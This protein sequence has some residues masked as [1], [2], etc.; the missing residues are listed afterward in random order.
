MYLFPIYITFISFFFSFF[1][2][3][4]INNLYAGILTSLSVF[5]GFI[6]SLFIF[7]EVAICQA[8]VLINCSNW[9]ITGLLEINWTFYYDS[10]TVT[11]L[12]VIL[13]ISACAH[14]YSIEY[15][16]NDPHQIKFMSYLS[17]FTFFML[18]LVTSSNFIILFVGWEGVGICSYLLINFW[19]TRVGA[20]KSAIMAMFV[21]KIGDVSLL[22]SFT[23]IYFIVYTFDF[24]IFFLSLSSIINTANIFWMFSR[25]VNTTLVA[26]LDNNTVYVS[27]DILFLLGLIGIF[28]VIGAVGKSAQ[29]G[30]HTWLPEAMEGPTPVS[31]LIH[32]ATMVTAGIFL[33][34]RTNILFQMIG[35]LFIVIIA[36]G[37]ITAFMGSTIGIFQA[38][39]KKI[40]AYS[41]CSQLGYMFLAC[42]L[43]GY[44]F[45]IYHLTNH[46]FF[47]AL[48]F[49][50][51]GYIIHAINN[52]QDIRKMGGL[53]SILPFAYI[54]LTIGSLSLLGFPF[55]SGFYSKE[56]IIELFYSFSNYKILNVYSINSII[57]FQMLANI[58][59]TFTVLYSVKVLVYVFFYSYQNNKKTLFNLHYSSFVTIIP[60]FFLSILSIGSGYLLEDMMVGFSTDLWNSSIYKISTGF[61]MNHINYFE[62]NYLS[63]KLPVYSIFY[64]MILFIILF[65]IMGNLLF[66]VKIMNKWTDSFYTFFNKKYILLNKNIYYP[67]INLFF[68]FSYDSM[69][70]LFDKGI[71][72]VLG[73][74]GIV[75]ILN[76]AIV[77]NTKMQTGMV[78]HYFGLMVL[79]ILLFILL[80]ILYIN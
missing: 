53:L 72:E 61:Y 29:V 37:S 5:S 38:D 73:P 8:P 42:G 50:V 57:F 25:L 66:Y 67:I 4:F 65:Y 17:L 69:Y 11:M 74:F 62:F 60:L 46:A 32:A 77:T 79:S 26:A 75:S 64:F 43:S 6:M 70:K 30:L 13:S 31:S 23:L 55:F 45:S 47:K 51:A 71:I 59:V 35:N 19:H 16:L 44:E 9:I 10:L 24:S 56:K 34:I 7:Y 54:G 78:Y 33:I 40:I 14:I 76:K 3:R 41:T 39:I 28:F 18:L 48:L 68:R 58:A 80:I 1:F 52:E 36:L 12:I 21:N 63:S 20:N 22:L 15:M 27:D 2:G 49:L